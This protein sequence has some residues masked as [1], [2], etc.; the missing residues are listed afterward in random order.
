M[1]RV[2]VIIPVYNRAQVVAEAIASVLGQTFQ[3]FELLVVDD[4]STDGAWEK[5]QSYGL[6]IRALRQDHRGAAAA[7]NF[8][9]KNATGEYLAFLDSDDLWRPEKLARQVEY[10]DRRPEVALVHCDGWVVKGRE[11]PA[12]LNSLPTFYATRRAPDGDAAAARLMSVPISTPHILVRREVA[13][14]IGGFA[15][16]LRLHEDADF[17]L[18]L[19][20]AGEKIGYVPE[21]LCIVRIPAD[22]QPGPSLEYILKSIE[23]QKRSLHR[24]TVL[25]PYLLPA[26]GRSHLL[27]A[28]ALYQNHDRTGFFCHCLAAW[29]LRPQSLRLPLAFLA[30]VLP[31]PWGLT[32]LT[33]LGAYGVNASLYT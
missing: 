3:D 22:T 32:Y 17:L 2:S 33:R 16:D 1:P 4:G 6:K 9:I 11:L 15:E 25:R 27:A 10:L 23:V 24:S 14:K 7:R 18:R 28:R 8:G 30:L 21:P 26:L 13:E 31:R 20:E 19:L 5:L 29:R 12:D